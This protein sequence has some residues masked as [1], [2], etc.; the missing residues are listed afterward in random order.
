[1]RYIILPYI[2][3]RDFSPALREDK[4]KRLIMD[5]YIYDVLD[6]SHSP[7]DY[8][9][10]WIKDRYP[11]KGKIYILEKHADVYSPLKNASIPFNVIIYLD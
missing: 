9:N 6:G 10:G 5:K 11:E 1:M 8:A 4:I 2:T 3:K 7:T